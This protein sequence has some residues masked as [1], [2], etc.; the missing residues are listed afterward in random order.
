MD[1]EAVCNLIP[2]NKGSFPNWQ[3]ALVFKT[4]NLLVFGF[5][6]ELIV[7]TCRAT[8]FITIVGFSL[9]FSQMSLQQAISLLDSALGALQSQEIRSRLNHHGLETKRIAM[10]PV[11]LHPCGTTS[12][13]ML[14]LM[15]VELM[16]SKGPKVTKVLPT[17]FEFPE[18]MFSKPAPRRV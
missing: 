8:A 16:L 5:L 17:A 6:L 12:F 18:N 14:V 13:L 9:L 15:L 4:L 2:A 3:N 11:R 1:S 7:A 10:S